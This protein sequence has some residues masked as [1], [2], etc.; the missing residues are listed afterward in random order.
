VA[1]AL[2]AV[3]LGLVIGAGVLWRRPPGD[4]AGRWTAT[5]AEVYGEPVRMRTGG[6]LPTMTITNDGDL[7]FSLYA[8]CNTMSGPL[9]YRAGG[10]LEVADGISSTAMGCP[11]GLMMRD[12][13][14]LQA[15]GRVDH[16]QIHEGRLEL[17]GEGVS[18]TFTRLTE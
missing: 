1:V 3:V 16:V 9:A 18:L 14:L 11:Q 2:G 10:S 4:L 12:T 8:G 15:L 5:S 17:T 13:T 7:E 6:T